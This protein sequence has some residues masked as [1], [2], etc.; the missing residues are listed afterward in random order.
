MDRRVR[1]LNS[2]IEDTKYNRQKSSL[3][4]ELQVFLKAFST[5]SFCNVTP[6]DICGFLIHKDRNEKTK[7][8]EINC[9]YIG[10]KS[11]N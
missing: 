3:D 7:I 4:R 9:Q 8:H 6:V 11:C 1:Y 2:L 5:N 10:E